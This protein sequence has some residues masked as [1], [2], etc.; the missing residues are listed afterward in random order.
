MNLGL[1]YDPRDE[2]HQS[3]TKEIA[4]AQLRLIGQSLLRK[5]AE[6]TNLLE[7]VRAKPYNYYLVKNT[8][9]V[10]SLNK[11]AK[12]KHNNFVNR[13]NCLAMKSRMKNRST[14]KTLR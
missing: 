4:D 9:L 10:L 3:I 12:P 14:L 8:S 1:P 11:T 2:V 5:V 6:D 7:A 13:T